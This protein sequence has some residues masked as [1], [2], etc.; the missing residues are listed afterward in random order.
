WR[1]GWSIA[2]TRTARSI[3]ALQSHTT[4]NAS[5][6]S[7]HAALC[8]LSARDQSNPA[9]ET[10]VAEFRRR[11][12][13]AA[14]LLKAAGVDFIEPRGAFYLFVRVP[15]RG[16]ESDSGTVFAGELLD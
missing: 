11:R 3:C 14:A 10:M 7:Q 8:A 6:L 16:E 1:I 9:I 4:S 13:A 15:S 5:T 12:D 2:P